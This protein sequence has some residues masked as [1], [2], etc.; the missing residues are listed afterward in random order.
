MKDKKGMMTG[1]IIM[2]FIIIV[3]IIGIIT[4]FTEKA[5]T[6]ITNKISSENMDKKAIEFCDNLINNPGTPKNWQ[7]LK[8]KNNVII[9]LSL[10]NENNAS[11]VN[12]VDY[13]KLMA[14]S[15]DYDKL[16]TKKVFDNQ[17]KSS[18]TLTPLTGTVPKIEIGNKNM[19][20]PTT[21]NRIVT[22]DFFKKYQINSF[23]NDGECNRYHITTHSCN[24]F[25]IYNNWLK[26]MDY[27]LLF[28]PNSYKNYYWSI[29]STQIPDIPKKAD[30]E[31]IYLNPIIDKKILLVNDGII[32]IHINQ[33]NPKAIIVA[34]PKD[35][36]KNKIYYDYFVPTECNLKIQ[37]AK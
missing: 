20:H 23:K 3:L 18:I 1:E 16:I 33:K 27:Y 25:K 9:G 8:N 36:D 13:S 24:H 14:L 26:K 7:E 37:I 28:E 30:N 2:L 6:Q 34:V 5:N 12:S 15:S 19:E 32:F 31:K 29:D 21:V 22:C 17:Y 11:V 35:F 10:V 4:T